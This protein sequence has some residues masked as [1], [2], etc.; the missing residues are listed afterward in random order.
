MIYFLS[1]NKNLNS[2]EL[3]EMKMQLKNKT[4]FYCRSV[5]STQHIKQTCIIL[6]HHVLDKGKAVTIIGIFNVKTE[7]GELEHV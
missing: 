6:R 3:I 7:V 1:K 5:T 4:R 2:L